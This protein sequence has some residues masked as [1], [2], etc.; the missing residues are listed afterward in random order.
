M[1]DAI[2]NI[3]QFIGG[4]IVV[5]GYI[6]QITKIIKTKRVRDLSAKS[7]MIILVGIIITQIYATY[8]VV[9]FGVGHMIFITNGAP[10]IIY[11]IMCILYR[12]YKNKGE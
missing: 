11:I 7:L 12:K 4:S 3:L 10:L 8:L 6:P 1:I 5:A 9:R 2:F